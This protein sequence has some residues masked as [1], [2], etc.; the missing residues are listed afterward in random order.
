[1]ATFEYV[2]RGANGQQ[3]T[4][5]MQAESEVAVA[6]TLDERKLFPIRVTEKAVAAPAFGGGKIRVRD[7]GMMYSQMSDLLRAGVPMLR[8][9]ETLGRSSH[10]LKLAAAINGV[11]EEVAAGKTLAEA[12]AGRPEAFA[13]LHVAMVRAG[14]QAGFLEDVLTNLA[15]FIERQDELSGKVK[16]ALIYPMVL[17]S[18]GTLLVVSMLIFVVPEF[19]EMFAGMTLPLPTEILF[20]ISALLVDH[21]FLALGLLTLATLAVRSVLRSEW[22]KQMWDNWRIRIPLAGRAMR[23][24]AITRFCRILGTMLANGVPLL[25]A[26]AISKD[27]AGLAQLEECISQASENVRAGEPLASPLRES[28]LFPDEILEMLAIAEESNQM[29]KVLVQIADTV[30]RRTARQVDHAVRLLEPLILVFMAGIIGFVAM[31]LLYP[32]FTMSQTI[33]K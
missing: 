33:G 8:V 21:V 3:V 28:G 31:G 13:T 17:L 15:S 26:L 32:I 6:R 24:V 12:M 14:E 29:E 2:A 16:G 22:G 23:M 30:E 11:R 25:Q 10:H 18:F 5:V 9:L 19:R 1:M 4:G 27:A 20:A 7:V